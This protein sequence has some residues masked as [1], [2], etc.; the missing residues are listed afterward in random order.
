MVGA[1]HGPLSPEQEVAML[2]DGEYLDANTLTISFDFVFRDAVQKVDE[3]QAELDGVP[4]TATADYRGA[5][6]ANL[7]QAQERLDYW[8]YH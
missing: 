4:S 8:K 7:M 2:T 5:I 3:L 6:G 1:W